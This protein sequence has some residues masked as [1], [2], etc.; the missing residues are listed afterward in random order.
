MK[1]ITGIFLVVSVSVYAAQTPLNNGLLQ[2]DLNANGK[3]FTNVTAL[4]LT[5][6]ATVT[7][8]TLHG[9]GSGLTGVVLQSGGFA[10]NLTATNVMFW[11]SHVGGTPGISLTL[12][13]SELVLSAGTSQFKWNNVQN[14]GGE[15][16]IVGP[17]GQ[18][19]EWNPNGEL[20][21]LD[22]G[23]ENFFM[24]ATA[25]IT[26]GTTSGQFNIPVDGGINWL[27]SAT[28]D[29]AGIINL[30]ATNAASVFSI[31]TNI[32]FYPTGS[33]FITCTNGM[34]GIWNSNGV[35]TYVR[36]STKGSKG[37]TDHLL[38]AH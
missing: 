9:D 21:F 12:S 17:Q 4:K 19:I 1:K 5:N 3:N 25:G 10:T 18:S 13:N 32:L 23:D 14:N 11:G 38:F 34:S 29:G 33:N 8:L 30:S 15:G 31:G 28:G 37:Y 26:M 35:A 7:G 20:A 36:T 22:S 16:D 24:N 27:G 6:G 2:S